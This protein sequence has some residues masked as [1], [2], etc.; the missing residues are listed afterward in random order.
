M[1]FVSFLWTSFLLKSLT[2]FFFY[3]LN[4]LWAS[5]WFLFSVAPQDFPP[6]NQQL[7]GFFSNLKP[8]SKG[9]FLPELGIPQVSSHPGPPLSPIPILRPPGPPHSQSSPF[10]SLGS[11][12]G[13]GVWELNFLR[14][15]KADNNSILPPFFFLPH[16]GAWGILS[17]PTRNWTH[18]PYS[19]SAESYHW[20][21]LWSP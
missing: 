3:R 6:V 17:F 10:P 21:P 5:C 11:F 16:W 4:F 14:F 18:S 9:A 20:T 8:S 15:F 2:I 19:G 12:L 1:I 7:F 13:K